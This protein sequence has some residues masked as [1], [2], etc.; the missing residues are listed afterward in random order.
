M[1]AGTRSKAEADGQGGIHRM[2]GLFRQLAHFFLEA[3]FVKS[4]HLLQEHDGI[5]GQAA[6]LGVS[7][8]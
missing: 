4:P 2:H 5:F 8:M 7:S 3:A 1:A 6:A